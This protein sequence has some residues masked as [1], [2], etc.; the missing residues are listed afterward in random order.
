MTKQSSPAHSG[1]D[2]WAGVNIR[3]S[4]R[5]DTLAKQQDSPPPSFLF[6]IKFLLDTSHKGIL[7]KLAPKFYVFQGSDSKT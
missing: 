2:L 6:F 4:G 3:G 1:A 7:E 5:V